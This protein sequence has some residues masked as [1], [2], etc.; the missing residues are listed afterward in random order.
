MQV[1]LPRVGGGSGGDEGEGDEDMDVD[2]EQSAGPS[3][4]QADSSKK[5]RA[6]EE[7]GCCDVL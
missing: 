6:G 1:E 3:S 5:G 7:L 2:G 4:A